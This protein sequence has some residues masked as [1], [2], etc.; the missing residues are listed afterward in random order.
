MADL[1]AFADPNHPGNGPAYHTGRPCIKAGCFRPAGT[2]WSPHWCF[3]CNVE[4]IRKISAS[5]DQLAPW[6]TLKDWWPLLVTLGMPNIDPKEAKRIVREWRALHAKERAEIRCCVKLAAERHRKCD[7]VEALRTFWK[8]LFYAAE[9]AERSL[10]REL[11]WL[12]ALQP[13]LAD[14]IDEWKEKGKW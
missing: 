1:P 5:L 9:G 14:R 6:L 10:R 12:R 4:R 2:W 3:E 8:E 13:K 11:R 7:D